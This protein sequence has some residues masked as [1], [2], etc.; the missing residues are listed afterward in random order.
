MAEQ[1][2]EQKSP[3]NTYL[4]YLILRIKASIRRT[5]APYLKKMRRA[6]LLRR[7]RYIFTDK[8]H[9]EKG[10]FSAALGCIALIGLILAVKVTFDMG[11]SAGIGQALTVLLAFLISGT[12][13][14]FG[15][16]ACRQKDV[17]KLFPHLGILFNTLS[18]M[19]C[20]AILCIGLFL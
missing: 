11:G 8:R 5:T 14:V 9:P 19:I 10:I 16:M 20:I 17:F 12:G 6:S 2:P 15:V 18:L 3:S 1:Q 7:E 13:F 4:H